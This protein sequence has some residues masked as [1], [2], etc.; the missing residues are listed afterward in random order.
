MAERQEYTYKLNEVYHDAKV[1]TSRLMKTYAEEY[2]Y[3]A[4]EEE[5]ESEKKKV[6]KFFAET[7]LSGVADALCKY[8]EKN[9]VYE[10]LD[11][12]E[13]FCEGK[14]IDKPTLKEAQERVALIAG[15]KKLNEQFS[16]ADEEKDAVE[17][18]CILMDWEVEPEDVLHCVKNSDGNFTMQINDG[19]QFTYD[20][21]NDCLVD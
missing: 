13:F 4:S 3:R 16:G 11:S 21:V 18:F 8:F 14:K 15:K 10:M 9:E 5:G 20:P 19:T 7:I 2:A 1:H 6:L 17:N 12:T